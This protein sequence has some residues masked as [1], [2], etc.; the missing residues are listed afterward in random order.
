MNT[1]RKL[2][3]AEAK[4]AGHTWRWFGANFHI[5]LID[6]KLLVA[7]NPLTDDGAIVRAAAEIAPPVVGAI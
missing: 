2:L 1:D 5:A 6:P 7:W 4:A 3:E